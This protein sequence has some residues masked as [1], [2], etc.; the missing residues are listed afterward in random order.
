MTIKSEGLTPARQSQFT[1]PRLA[2]R[3]LDDAEGSEINE[4]F[5]FKHEEKKNAVM[6]CSDTFEEGSDNPA[7]S[8]NALMA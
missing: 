3:G 2:W 6:S 7:V 4:Y 8:Q 5:G 1:V